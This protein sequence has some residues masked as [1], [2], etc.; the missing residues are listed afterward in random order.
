MS[1]NFELKADLL[2]RGFF[3]ANENAMRMEY[4]MGSIAHYKKCVITLGHRTWGDMANQW[5]YWVRYESFAESGQPEFDHHTISECY[6]AESKIVDF[7]KDKGILSKA[8]LAD[9][10]AEFKKRM[11]G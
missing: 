9:R 11:R 1:I 5:F 4:A 6:V 7:L 10:R 2:E 8:E 3:V